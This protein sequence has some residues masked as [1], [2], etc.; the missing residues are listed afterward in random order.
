MK[1]IFISGE[2]TLVDGHIYFNNNVIKLRYDLMKKYSNRLDL[3][4]LFFNQYKNILNL[5]EGETLKTN[6]PID[7]P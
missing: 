5:R 3:Q 1:G 7:S 6:C 4:H 2:Y